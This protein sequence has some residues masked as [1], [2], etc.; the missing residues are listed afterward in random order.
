MSD[1]GFDP[2]ER[3][4][5]VYLM[6]DCS[7]SMS[8]EPIAALG[9]GVNSLVEELRQDPYALETVWLSVI[10]FGST[11]DQAVPLTEI[12]TFAPPPLDAGGSTALGEALML[13]EERLGAEVRFGSSE[14]KA[15]WK[16]MVFL[17]TD[18]EPTDRWR[19][20]A[21]RLRDS[22]RVNLVACGAGPAVNTA[23][24]DALSDTV[25]RLHDTAPGTLTS[26]LRW[27][28]VAVTAASHS[29]GTGRDAPPVPFDPAHTPAPG[30][31]P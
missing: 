25:I 16:P 26:F 7:G 6:L 13:L 5:P 12:D 9:V 19:D 21:K 3:R 20:P 28:T 4:L 31:A 11:A 27:V 14:Q 30:D 8:G 24:L 10:T 2:V 23:T 15:D 1:V 17:F 29:L 22:H 18:G